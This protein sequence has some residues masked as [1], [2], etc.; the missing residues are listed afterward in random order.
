LAVGT[1][2]TVVHVDDIGTVHVEWHCGSRLGLILDP[3]AGCP[4]DR[5]EPGPSARSARTHGRRRSSNGLGE[6]V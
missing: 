5:I 1:K 6:H 3:P 2:G 4:A